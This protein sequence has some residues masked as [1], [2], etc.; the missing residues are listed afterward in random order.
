MIYWGQVAVTHVSWRQPQV[1]GAAVL[2]TVLDRQNSNRGESLPHHQPAKHPDALQCKMWPGYWLSIQSRYLINLRWLTSNFKGKS[3]EVWTGRLQWPDLALRV[4]TVGDQA[5]L[6]NGPGAVQQGAELSLW[7]EPPQYLLPGPGAEP[8]ENHTFHWWPAGWLTLVSLC[9]CQ[10][11]SNHSRKAQR[12]S[13][14]EKCEVCGSLREAQVVALHPIL[15]LFFLQQDGHG[16]RVSQ[17]ELLQLLPL[18]A[19]GLASLHTHRQTG[20]WAY[21]ACHLCHFQLC[22]S[23]S[24]D[25]IG[26]SEWFRPFWM[27]KTPGPI[28]IFLQQHVDW[29]LVFYLFFYYVNAH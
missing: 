27:I 18:H 9:G 2:L 24:H 16:G 12:R 21:R 11:A 1:E 25:L 4:C 10:A 19:E 22:I 5:A 17:V 13:V 20:S 29:A 7:K 8:P 15:L 28:K 14:P 26:R 6:H 3:A 23:N